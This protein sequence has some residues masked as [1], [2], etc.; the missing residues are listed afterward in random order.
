M[1][2]FKILCTEPRNWVCTWLRDIHSWP[3]QAAAQQNLQTFFLS[4][5]KLPCLSSYIANCGKVQ[6]N[7]DTKAIRSIQPCIGNKMLNKSRLTRLPKLAMTKPQIQIIN[8][9]QQKKQILEHLFNSILHN[10][11]YNTVLKNYNR[12]DSCSLLIFTC[13][14]LHPK[15]HQQPRFHQHP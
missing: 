5:V 7:R 2:M 12:Y 3:R 15:L 1:S 10:H 13:G 8:I 6:A 9:K 11:F 14:C 4:P